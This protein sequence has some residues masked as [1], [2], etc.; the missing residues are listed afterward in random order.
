MTH[1]ILP[2]VHQR[3]A[4]LN[5]SLN[6]LK[7][8]IREAVAGE[9]SRVISEAVRDL[10]TAQLRS[11]VA[12]RP[13]APARSVKVDETVQCADSHNPRQTANPSTSRQLKPPSATALSFSM[14]FL[15][16][17]WH[18]QVPLWL[19][20]GVA[21][22]VGLAVDRA[23]PALQAPLAAITSATDLITLTNPHRN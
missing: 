18:R 10:L 22:L 17:M 14:L 16:W 23:G 20:L 5:D 11:Q 12:P 6:Q 3:M 1:S 8:R 13:Y 21:I 15:R 2:H 4:H 7:V 9:L 19:N